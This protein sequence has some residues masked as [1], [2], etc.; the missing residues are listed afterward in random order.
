MCVSEARAG[1]CTS[2]VSYT[3]GF[4]FTV[5]LKRAFAAVGSSETFFISDHK[6]KGSVSDFW[7]GSCRSDLFE[8]T[9][10]NGK[11]TGVPNN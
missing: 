9:L 8:V 6:A 3:L 5:Q 4:P 2:C 7:P 1:V 11:A 10:F